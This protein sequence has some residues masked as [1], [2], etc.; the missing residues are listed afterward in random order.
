MN[1]SILKSAAIAF[2]LSRAIVFAIFIAGSQ[3]AFLGK[4]YSSAVWETRIEIEQQRFAPELVRETLVGDAWWYRTISN[5]GYA[6][7]TAPPSTWNWTF[8]PLYPLL[9]RAVPLTSEFGLNALLVSNA[10]FAVALVLLGHVALS[11]RAPVEDAQRAIMYAAFFPTSYFFSLPM[12]EATFLALSLAA[13][14]AAQRRRWLIAGFA[15]G[16]TALTRF[17]GILLLP[18]LVIMFLI[19]ERDRWYRMLTLLLVPAGTAAFMSYLNYRTGDALAFVHAQARWGRSAT[20]FWQP[21]ASYLGHISHVSEPWNLLTLNFLV[22]VGCLALGGY[23]LVTREWAFGVYTLGSVLVP[24][25]SGSL[26][27]MSRY[28]LVIFPIYLW[29]A[30]IGRRQDLDRT[31]LASEAAVFGCLTVLFVGH[32]DFA[33]A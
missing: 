12:T 28:A 8:F 33:V 25:M 30:R 4:V 15:G 14:L 31:I 22:S 32:L 24:L 29:L 16:L 23:L 20:G 6:P 19:E 13:V 10:A 17:A 26:Q 2:V 11:M 27:S 7:K 9:V 1:R 18:V 3:T 21:L 5:D